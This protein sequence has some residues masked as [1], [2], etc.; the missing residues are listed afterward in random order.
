MT[1]ADSAIDGNEAYDRGGGICNTGTA[2]IISSTI[3][4][5]ASPY[6]GGICNAG[7]GILNGTALIY[8][9]SWW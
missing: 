8:L 4:F 2:S 5:N 6:G 3:C 7:Q 9:F 1:L